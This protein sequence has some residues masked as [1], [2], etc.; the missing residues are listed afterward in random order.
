M[1]VQTRNRRAF[2]EAELA[3]YVQILRERYAPQ[4]ILLFGSLASGEVGE[5]SDIDLVVV[6]ETDRKFLDRIREVMQ[7][8]RPRVGMDILVYTPEE[9]AQLSQE[10]PF[11]REEILHKGRVLYERE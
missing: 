2:L 7:L 8:L 5:W 6:K 11:V 9:F 10:R 3:R 1:D 4:R